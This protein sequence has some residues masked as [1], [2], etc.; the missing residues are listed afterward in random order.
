MNDGTP[1]CAT[2]GQNRNHS[3]PLPNQAADLERPLGGG[4]IFATAGKGA[5]AVV[6]FAC[7]AE[8][9]RRHISSRCFATPPHIISLCHS[10]PSGT[11]GRR[12]GKS[13]GK[14]RHWA[15]WAKQEM[16]S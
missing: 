8:L 2:A 12:Q 7:W 3:A 1:V 4:K 9:A 15:E 13:G 11:A 14:G 10:Q 16:S 5:V 6:G